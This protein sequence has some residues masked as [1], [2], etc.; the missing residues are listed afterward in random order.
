MTQST[1]KDTSL[2]WYA[3]SV[4]SGFEKK[5]V[6]EITGK[7][8]TAGLSESFGDMMIPTERV[9]ELKDGKK[10]ETE[11]RL[12]PGYVFI[13]MS[14]SDDAWFLVRNATKVLGFLGAKKGNKPNPLPKNEIDRLLNKG[15]S[16]E[17]K[18]VMKSLFDVGEVVRVSE[19]PFSGFQGPVEEINYE[20]HRLVVSVM[21]FGRSTPVELEFG[22]V[23]KIT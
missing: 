17:A 8:V 15:E 1:D 12:M 3:V 23:E 21:I 22:Q 5:M 20:K 6:Q 13:E 10:R 4:A 16:E 19:G 2:N 18:P 7:I 9:I 11:K 14:M